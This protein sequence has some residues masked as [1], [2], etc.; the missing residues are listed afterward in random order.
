MTALMRPGS[1]S[2][3]MAAALMDPPPPM[4]CPTIAMAEVLASSTAPA[5]VGV[6]VDV[7]EGG[8][9]AAG[10]K[11]SEVRIQRERRGGGDLPLARY[12]AFLVSSMTYSVV[13]TCSPP[14]RKLL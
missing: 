1:D 5:S 7:D 13:L 10:A 8:G 4:E 2:S 14:G 12:L 11:E 9:G 6:G 3:S